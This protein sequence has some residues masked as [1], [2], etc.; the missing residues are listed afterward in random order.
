MAKIYRR[1]RL[2]LQNYKVTGTSL[3]TNK[4]A[5]STF[6]RRLLCPNSLLTGALVL[7]IS[8]AMSDVTVWVTRS[9]KGSHIINRLMAVFVVSTVL[10]DYVHSFSFIFITPAAKL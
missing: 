6:T 3:L 7:N 1:H 8:A 9:G 5:K 10:S 4:K 2:T